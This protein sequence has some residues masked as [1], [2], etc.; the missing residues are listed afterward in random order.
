[1]NIC[2]DELARAVFL[3][4][5]FLFTFHCIKAKIKEETQ[6]GE[7]YENRSCPRTQGAGTSLEKTLFHG[8][9][10]FDKRVNIQVF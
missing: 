5:R 6:G 7:C 2:R 1:M 8:E 3:T 4:D 9:M 10:N